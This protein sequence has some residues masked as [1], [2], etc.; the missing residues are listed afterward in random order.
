MAIERAWIFL[1]LPI[2]LTLVYFRRQKSFFGFPSLDLIPKDW[3]ARA[4]S[5][6]SG[7]APLLL[8]LLLFLMAAGLQIPEKGHLKYGYGAD[9]VFILD[10]SRSMADPFEPNNNSQLPLTTTKEL[11]KFH[12]AKDA[13]KDFM[14]KRKAGRDRYGLTVFGSFAVR[15]LP[16]SFNHSLFLSCLDAQ[17]C[18]LTTTMIYHALA[19][20]LA[21]LTRSKT[22]SRILIFVSDGDGPVKDEEYGFSKIIREEGIRFY[23]ISLATDTFDVLPQFLMK[24]GPLGKRIDAANGVQLEAAFT[25]IH[26]ME[27]SL[28]R[29]RSSS[30][31]FSPNPII[32]SIYLLMVSIWVAESLFVYNR[33]T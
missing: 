2:V 25:K 7:T 9:I 30:R 26:K 21:E 14:E 33:K 32:Y 18:I 8:M 28:I 15:V 1:L 31:A 6:F 27:P 29:Y 11:S 4:V 3:G 16:L 13:I 20:A 10:E 23:W 17:E 5:F 19:L 12:M 24:I 22:R